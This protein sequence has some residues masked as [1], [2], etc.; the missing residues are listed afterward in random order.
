MSTIEQALLKHNSPGSMMRDSIA[1]IDHGI[2]KCFVGIIDADFG[3]QAPLK[4]FWPCCLH[5]GEIL[6]IFFDAVVSVGGSDTVPSLFTH[7]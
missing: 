5:R 2:P 1:S 3:T 4:T 6:E 7:L